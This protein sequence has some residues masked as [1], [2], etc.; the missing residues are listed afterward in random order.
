VF[1]NAVEQRG[2]TDMDSVERARF[3]FIRT[4]QGRYSRM[5]EGR[6]KGE[7]AR[8]T[9]TTRNGNPQKVNKWLNKIDRLEAVSERLR[10]VQIESRDANTVMRDYDGEQVL[11]YLDP[12]Y[13]PDTR[14]DDSS[15]GD[16]D[17]GIPEHKE[18][19]SVVKEVEG[20]VALSGYENQLY[21]EELDGWYVS[22]AE[23]K[24]NQ[25]GS[26]GKVSD[27]STTQEVLWTNYDP[28]S[29][30]P[31]PQATSPLEW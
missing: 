6:T 4:Q 13:V 5:G 14:G 7:W 10:R 17:F 18:L 8:S 19:L 12:P 15:Y 25:N 23:S 1:E 2:D 30:D 22:R 21:M 11:F 16:L 3:F 24:T 26:S 29:I 27:N 28:D 31:S 20:R 9:T